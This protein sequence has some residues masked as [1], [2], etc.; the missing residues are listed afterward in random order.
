MATKVATAA[1][2]VVVG[3][4]EGGMALELKMAQVSLLLMAVSGS[5]E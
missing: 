3:S 4:E 2:K 1:M 5:E